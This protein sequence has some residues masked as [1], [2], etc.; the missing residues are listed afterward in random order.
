MDNPYSSPRNSER[1]KR[2]R[3]TPL[4]WFERVIAGLFWGWVWSSLVAGAW[5][6]LA[7]LAY[8]DISR[9]SEIVMRKPW[10]QYKSR[11]LWSPC[12][13]ASSVVSSAHSRIEPRAAESVG[14]SCSALSSVQPSVRQSVRSLPAPPSGFLSGV[15][16]GRCS[17][18]GWPSAYLCR[19]A[20]LADGL[21]AGLFSETGLR[22]AVRQTSPFDL[23]SRITHCASL[24]GRGS[25]R[26]GI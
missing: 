14:R 4:Q 9:A 16:P 5:L 20:C 2:P 6:G 19:L 15:L 25:L 21:A 12:W 10:G 24:P 7:A 23:R 8:G 17:G 1:E 3:L 18:C 13:G 11:L 26:L 22:P